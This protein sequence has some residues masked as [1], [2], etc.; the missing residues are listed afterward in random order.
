MYG[1]EEGEYLL[2]NNRTFHTIQ[3]SIFSE[4]LVNLSFGN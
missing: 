4:I 3:L 2:K 1:K